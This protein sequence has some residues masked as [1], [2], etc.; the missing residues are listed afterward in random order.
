MTVQDPNQMIEMMM[1]MM[2]NATAASNLETETEVVDYSNDIT[3]A[4]DVAL[5]HEQTYLCTGTV[6]DSSTT[7]GGI[8]SGCTI[9]ISGEAGIGKTRLA[10]AVAGNLST[11][12]PVGYVTS[13]EPWTGRVG[14][15]ALAGRFAEIS[16]DANEE[17]VHVLD[18]TQF[19]GA[20]TW[21]DFIKRYRY[22]IEEVEVAVVIIDS[23]TALDPSRRHSA[24]HM[25]SLRSYN[26]KHGV[27]CL[28]LSQV[29]DTGDPNGGS[30][31]IHGA[32][33]HIDFSYKTAS[34]KQLA[35][36]WGVEPKGQITTMQSHKSVVCRIPCQWVR[37]DCNGLGVLCEYSS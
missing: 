26:L 1:T 9:S 16:P 25:A 13:E 7:D 29:K 30:A 3:L 10:L 24:E 20:S 5:R 32:D 2:A 34:N 11:Q 15:Q 14:R 8:P 31:L 17:S 19:D 33:M 37:V 18:M 6:L 28:V 35:A 21:D 36:D 4:S 23:L 27:T 12:M 22:L